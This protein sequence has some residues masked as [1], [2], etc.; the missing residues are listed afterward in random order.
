[1]GEPPIVPNP[2]AE[3]NPANFVGR[4]ETT[5]RALDMLRAGQNILVS[6]PRRMG[7]T[8]WLVWFAAEMAKGKQFRVVRI[9]YQG[10][11]SIDEFLRKTI[12][13]LIKTPGLPN[14][15]LSYLKGLFDNIDVGAAVGPITLKAAHRHESSGPLELLSNI[16][17]RL[18]QDLA[19]G[20]EVPLVI[21]MDEVPDAVESISRD[22]QASD[23][24]NLLE[25]LRALRHASRR[26][27]WIVAGSIGFHHVWT[28]CGA[29]ES[30]INDLNT[31][32]I[33]PLT[34]ADAKT[35]ARRLALGIHRPIDQL[36]IQTVVDVTGGIP[37]L[38]QKL[39]DL[40]R[41]DERG[42][43]ATG[44]ITAAGVMACFDA[45]VE[46]RDQSRDVAQFLSRIEPYYTGDAPLAYAILDAV[47]TT[48][49]Q[50]LR[51][52][53]LPEAVR[54]HEHFGPVLDHL[55]DDHYL[56]TRDGATEVRWRYDVLRTIYRRRRHLGR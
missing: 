15:F 31:L 6:D 27:H 26:V 46:D 29:D 13:G 43:H 1:V 35:L 25:R 7:K 34:P 19:E 11:N 17:A 21:A 22:G 16:L 51:L 32:A 5:A 41:Y 47:A 28:A 10:V 55:I 45:Y 33:G 39:F 23:G 52:A 2:G 36:A 54:G 37:Y 12:A 8:F 30:V 4:S 56:V 50:W 20:H 24:V 42:G 40:M 3:L 18:D 49:S 38:V 14:R 9:D 48:V 44:P 53:D